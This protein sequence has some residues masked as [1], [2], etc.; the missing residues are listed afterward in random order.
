M[1]QNNTDIIKGRP[2]KVPALAI[3]IFAALLIEIFFFNY[4]FWESLTF[5]SVSESWSCVGLERI[6][7]NVY[8]ANDADNAAI[9]YDNLNTPVKNL[10]LQVFKINDYSDEEVY[11]VKISANDAG[12]AHLF[13]FPETEILPAV[14][15]S[16]FIRT[17]LVG[18]TTSVKAQIRNLENG[19]FYYIQAGI[20]QKRDLLLHF[21]RIIFVFLLLG[22]LWLF[23]PNSHLYKTKVDFANR[24]QRIGIVSAVLLIVFSFIIVGSVCYVEDP[25]S[26]TTWSQYGYLAQSIANGK[27][28][29]EF[30]APAVL[31]ELSNPYDTGVRNAAVLEHNE[32]YILDLAYYKGHYYSYFGVVPVLLFHLPYYLITG[33]DLDTFFPIMICGI[34]FV[35]ACFWFTASLI[36]RY[37]TNA[38]LGFYL[39]MSSLLVISSEILYSIH[40]PILYSLPVTTA[41]VLNIFGLSCW[42][43]ATDGNGRLNKAYLMAGAFSIALV[44]GCRPQLAITLLFAFPLFR[45]DIKAKRFFSKAGLGNTLCVIVPFLLIGFGLMHYNYIRFGNP[46][47][48]GATYNLTGFDMTHR[49]F[50]PDRF[51]LGVF[52]YLFQPF[53]VSP[54]YPYL[55]V[56]AGF[57]QLPSDYQGQ[58]INEPLLG[59][60]F[61]FNTIGL[62]LA[63]LPSCRKHLQQKGLYSFAAASLLMG[64]IIMAVDI[65]MVGMTLRYLTDFSVFIMISVIIVIL[66]IEETSA[67][68]GTYFLQLRIITALVFLCIIINYLSL[69]ADGRFNCFRAE[70]PKIFFALKYQLFSFLSIR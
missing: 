20:N 1:K 35:P 40:F 13:A 5:N 65:Q 16:M 53:I 45:E 28:Y 33:T 64:L 32:S 43:N 36:K 52:E 50:I 42:I 51:W 56:I 17:H 26:N 58:T 63:A 3:L 22:I 14:P 48:F 19:E 55:S 12:S 18:N 47:D 69:I 67:A 49:G 39:L 25:E 2:H 11:P 68:D 59:G 8:L 60:F 10:Y 54:K 31:Q 4:R 44:M 34:L 41:L 46:L 29:L 38:S 70:V 9:C 21:E 57:M 24:A 62:Y 30:E 23:R 6:R 15:E 7:D 61:A 27:P 66:T 37:F